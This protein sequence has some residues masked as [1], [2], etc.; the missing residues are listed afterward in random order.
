MYNLEVT[1]IIFQE[2]LTSYLVIH[3]LSYANEPD[4]IYGENLL[5]GHCLY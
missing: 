2:I 5:W 1:L 3:H 4:I